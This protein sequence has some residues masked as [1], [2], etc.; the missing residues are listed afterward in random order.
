MV[1][2]RNAPLPGRT[3]QSPLSNPRH[4]HNT[5]PRNS[6]NLKRHKSNPQKKK[7]RGEFQN[8][9]NPGAADGRRSRRT[10]LIS[11]GGGGGKG[12]RRRR[13]GDGL[14]VD[15]AAGAAGALQAPRPLRRRLQR[16]P[17]RPPRRDPLGTDSHPPT[18]PTIVPSL[19][20]SSSSFVEWLVGCGNALSEFGE[21]E[22]VEDADRC[23][24]LFWICV[25]CRDGGEGGRGGGGEGM[26]EAVGRR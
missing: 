9:A 23:F 7:T 6:S 3:G 1:P 13:D 12:G 2:T 16:R 24:F 11:G 10:V 25:G 19:S 8:F 15:E 18:H 5:R 21:M 20:I 17:R 14:R 22:M 26:H 4:V